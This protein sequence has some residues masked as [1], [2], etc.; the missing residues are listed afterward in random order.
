MEEGEPRREGLGE[1]MASSSPRSD[2][3]PGLQ[4]RRTSNMQEE[5]KGRIIYHAYAVDFIFLRGRRRE[6]FG[7]LD[8]VVS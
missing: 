1:N 2:C 5:Q 8:A 4:I 6:T 3:N 7:G